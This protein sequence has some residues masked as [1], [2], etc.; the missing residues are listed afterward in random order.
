M[1][2]KCNHIRLHKVCAMMYNSQ[3]KIPVA[4][5]SGCKKLNSNKVK[6]SY[7]SN[8]E[9]GCRYQSKHHTH[10]YRPDFPYYT[11]ICYNTPART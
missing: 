7:Q 4:T 11:T 9:H 3:T 5:G 2:D 6:P 10:H 8:T 1:T